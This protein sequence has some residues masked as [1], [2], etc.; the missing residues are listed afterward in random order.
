MEC[1]NPGIM[2]TL[3]LSDMLLPYSIFPLFHFSFTKMEFYILNNI[4]KNW[5]IKTRL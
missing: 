3:F 4:I 2:E 1:W 5:Q